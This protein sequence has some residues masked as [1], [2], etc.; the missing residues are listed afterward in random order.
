[1]HLSLIILSLMLYLDSSKSFF[2]V[3][4]KHFYSLCQD[5]RT[6]GLGQPMRDPQQNLK[7]RYAKEEGGSTVIKYS[8]KRDTG[9]TKNDLAIEV[10]RKF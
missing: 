9:D 3:L 10:N 8:R 4:Q 7:L 2:R 6:A 1:M 5:Y